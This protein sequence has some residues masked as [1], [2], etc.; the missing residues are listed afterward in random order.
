VRGEKG[1]KGKVVLPL[2]KERAGGQ[3]AVTAKAAERA[4]S[5]VISE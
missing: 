2:V 4:R 3:P 1:K 5:M